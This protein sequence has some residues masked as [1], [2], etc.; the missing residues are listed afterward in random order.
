MELNLEE[1]FDEYPNPLFIIRPIVRDGLSE[2][3]EYIYANKSFCLF[4]GHGQEELVGHRFKEFFEKGEKVWLNLFL[5]AAVNKKHDYAETVSG[6][7]GRRLYAEVFHIEPDLCGCLIHDFQDI[8]EKLQT[9]ENEK[10]R[11]RANIDYLTGFYNRFYLREIERDIIARQNLGITFM[12]INDLKLTND[13]QG[14]AA[15]DALIIRV[16]DKIRALYGNSLVFRVGGDEF[17]IITSGC[18]KDSFLQLSEKN[19]MEFDREKLAAVGFQFYE[20][21]ENLEESINRCDEL[22]YEHK[23]QMKAQQ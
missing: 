18:A 2:D 8:S 11:Q 3:F 4:L 14:H 6:L 17:V 1:A 19:R 22:M 15:G 23:R 9:H 10:L 7:I 12:D 13:T 21:V 5:N 20:K 16:A